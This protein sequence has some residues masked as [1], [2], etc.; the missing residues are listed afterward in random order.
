MNIS[1]NISSISSHQTMLNTSA[2]NVA[3]V[4]TDGFKPSSTVITNNGESTNTRLSDDTGSTTSQTD[5][6]IEFTNQI[7]AQN[8]VEFNVSAIKMQDEMFGSLLDIK[9]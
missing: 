4:N 1:S 7:V 8:A 5:L 6:A 9:A 2:H 3:N